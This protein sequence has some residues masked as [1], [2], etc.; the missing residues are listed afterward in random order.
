M[1]QENL[2]TLHKYRYLKWASTLNLLCLFLY[3]F[4]PASG[5]AFGSTFAGY[6]LG[7]LGALIIV[8]LLLFGIRKRS[9][10]SNLGTVK[11]WLSAHIY[12]GLSLILIT[13]LHTGFQ[14]SLN[15]Q[16]LT[17]CLTLIVVL[18]GIWG[19]SSYLTQPSV[20]NSA[21]NGNSL[22]ACAE[23]IL[24]IDRE[25][26]LIADQLSSEIQTII[27]NSASTDVFNAPTHRYFGNLADSA[28]SDAVNYLGKIYASP[29]QLTKSTATAIEKL[30]MLQLK[31]QLEL[32]RVREYL[33]SKGWN[34]IWLVFHVS[35]SFALLAA[36]ITHIITVFMYW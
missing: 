34:E 8:L 7:I 22:E 9:Y 10:S 16:T 31:R 32:K 30:Y 18:S 12:L 6:T 2:L 19:V 24:E 33:R 25:S 20:I 3:F 17:Y 4:Q 29:A 5:G 36:L 13:T 35:A 23:S 11:G 26:K 15:V 28:T 1:H 27:E 21:L 14:L